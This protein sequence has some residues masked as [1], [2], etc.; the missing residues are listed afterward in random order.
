[1]AEKDER[2]DGVLMEKRV[3]EEGVKEVAPPR[4]QEAMMA[5]A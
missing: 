5:Q 1:M 4:V 3:K 2:K